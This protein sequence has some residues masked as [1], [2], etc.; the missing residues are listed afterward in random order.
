[1]NEDA[2]RHEALDRAYTISVMIEELLAGHPGLSTPELHL[3][4]KALEDAA[5][6]LYQAIGAAE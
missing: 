3:K 1:M 5:A 4:L 6:D 2:L